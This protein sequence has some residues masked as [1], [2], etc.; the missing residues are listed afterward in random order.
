MIQQLRKG[1]QAALA[2]V[3]ITVLFLILAP[4][5]RQWETFS[6]ILEQ[7]TVLA[8]MAVGTT[9]VLISGGLDLS[10]GS[11][12]ALSTCVAGGLL[13]S[14]A[15]VW[16]A[17]AAGVGVGLLVGLI[18]GL[19]VA[20]TNV[21]PFIVTL[22]MMMAA[23]GVALMAGEGRDMSGFP[24]AF[25]AIGS[26]WVV[27]VAIA[28]AVAA[29]VAAVLSTTRFGF[30]VYAVGGNAEVARLSGVPVRRSRVICYGLGGL[31]A[32]LAAVVQTAKFDFATPNRG[33]GWELQAIAAAV[34]GGTSLFGGIGGVGRT[35]IG[36]LIIKS[37]ETG[38]I[39]C[40]V[41]SYWQKVAIGCVIV[42]AVWIDRLQRRQKA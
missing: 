17:V 33:E 34:I 36:V 24:P 11:I 42:V 19:T 40:G 1:L 12:L 9:V 25:A 20:M 7:S 6:G 2:L 18:N 4:T 30:H 38:L 22:G 31:L 15:P 37:L 26:G 32:G 3:L 13:A 21:P 41:G 39:H 23:R 28:A 27:P 5:Y 8:I 14:G 10:V 35:I 29:L 16:S